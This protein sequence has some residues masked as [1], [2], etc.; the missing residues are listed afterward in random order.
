MSANGHPVGIVFVH[1]MGGTASTWALVEPLLKER[2]HATV[3][4]TNPLTTLS[5]DVAAT[6]RAIDELPEGPVLLVGHSYG[7]AVITNAGR[8]PR[9]AGL[10]YVA[11]FAPAEGESVNQIVERYPP[12]EAAKYMLRGPNG[13]WRSDGSA[14]YWA[15]VAF[16]LPE[17]MRDTIADERRDSANAI[18]TEPT[19]EPAWATRPTWYVVAESDKTLRPDTQRDMARRTGG[20]VYTF[21]GSHYTPWTQPVQVAGVVAAAADAVAAGAPLPSTVEAGSGS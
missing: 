20:A 19:G 18:F 1:G 7:G 4:V 2:G 16:D 11:A 6:T 14:A 3:C 10:V 13:E 8:D 21:P 5:A 12:A 15:E 17:H 9:V